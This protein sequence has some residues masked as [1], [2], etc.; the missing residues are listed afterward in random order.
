MVLHDINLCAQVA[1]QVI[2]LKDAK[3]LKQ[4]SVGE[5]LNPLNIKEALGLDVQVIKAEGIDHP[6]LLPC[7]TT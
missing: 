3:L 2:M 7:S 6:I 1:D 4:G 5:T